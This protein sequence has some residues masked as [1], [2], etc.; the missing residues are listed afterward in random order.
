MPL[1]ILCLV[2]LVLTATPVRADIEKAF[3]EVFQL[4]RDRLALKK[5]VARAAA[6][7]G[8]RLLK[9]PKEDAED[10]GLIVVD[11]RV[12]HV[13]TST[14][15]G[16]GTMD[17]EMKDRTFTFPSLEKMT[18]ARRAAAFRTP[19]L[20]VDSFHA[21]LLK[22]A[23]DAAV[24]DKGLRLPV[25]LAGNA[26]YRAQALCSSADARAC[27]KEIA[28]GINSP[29]DEKSETRDATLFPKAKAEAKDAAPFLVVR[30][31]NIA[32]GYKGVAPK[33][34]VGT[35]HPG[36]SPDVLGTQEDL[37]KRYGKLF[38]DEKSFGILDFVQRF[39]IADCD[40]YALAL[41]QLNPGKDLALAVGNMPNG[42]GLVDPFTENHAWNYRYEDKQRAI[43]SIEN[44]PSESKVL[45]FG[46]TAALRKEI[47]A[48]AE[49]LDRAKYTAED[50]F[51][52][53]DDRKLVEEMYAKSQTMR[54]KKKDIVKNVLDLDKVSLENPPQWHKNADLLEKTHLS[55]SGAVVAP[56]GTGDYFSND[57]SSYFLEFEWDRSYGKAGELIL[58]SYRGR[59]DARDR[60]HY[61]GALPSGTE[62]ASS[63][64]SVGA[65]R[66]T[67]KD[68]TLRVRVIHTEV[69]RAKNRRGYRWPTIPEAELRDLW[70]AFQKAFPQVSELD[71]LGTPG[72]NEGLVSGPDRLKSS[73]DVTGAGF[74]VMYINRGDRAFHNPV[75]ASLLERNFQTEPLVRFWR[76]RKYTV[77][78]T[79][80]YKW[81]LIF[82]YD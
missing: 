68:R 13:W 25:L 11:V 9:N 14:A 74:G 72:K 48:R 10:Y 34:V 50:L 24:S 69:S 44:T 15:V 8:V 43:E 81:T 66:T 18:E 38:K 42:T 37:F 70:P 62:V 1:L 51:D 57:K 77:L 27:T 49:K 55:L 80:R 67:L 29:L 54:F 21:V 63:I 46:I 17:L 78:P 73:A 2:S 60:V 82:Y 22:K 36:Y 26:I 7:G 52:A 23:V 12:D 4:E 28:K 64:F 45:T 16:K 5:A 31:V 20:G 39:R 58:L 30:Y 19:G 75:L 33:Q 61:G 35:V 71:V 41:V 47:A 32:T 6:K 40:T 65:D 3:P 79:L 59:D 76:D 56:G 53:A